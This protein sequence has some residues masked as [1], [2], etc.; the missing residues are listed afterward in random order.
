MRMRLFAHTLATISGLPPVS[1][2]MEPAAQVTA[3]TVARSH[4]T[5]ASLADVNCVTALGKQQ[6]AQLGERIDSGIMLAEAERGFDERFDELNKSFENVQ[7]RDDDTILPGYIYIDDGN[8]EKADRFPFN[9][10]VSWAHPAEIYPGSRTTVVVHE[11][12]D[13]RA[14]MAWCLGKSA[15]FKRHSDHDHDVPGA[16]ETLVA[17]LPS[18]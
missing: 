9:S 8:P 13:G 15:G 6:A 5:K 2:T 1:P 3:N 4:C 7:A 18:H 11:S 12:V 17:V 16:E 10:A 14:H